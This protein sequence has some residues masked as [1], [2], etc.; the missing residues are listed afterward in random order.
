MKLGFSIN[1][2]QDQS[3]D[4]AFTSISDI[5]YDGIEFVLDIPHGFLPIGKIEVGKIKKNLKRTGLEITNLNAN[6]VKGFYNKNGKQKFEPSLSSNNIK[7]RKW[8]INYTKQAID[9]AEELEAPS[10]SITSGV[11]N[12]SKNYNN[13]EES[14][15]ELNPYAEKKN[16]LISIE[17]EP[18]LMIENYN[19]VLPF[20]SKE[21]KNVGVNFDVCHSAVLNENIPE[22][23]VKLKNKLFHTHISDCKNRVHYH[24]IP[25]MGKIDFNSMY[26]ALKKIDYD[27]FLTGELYTYLHEPEKAAKETYVY[28]KNLI[29]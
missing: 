10:I 4:Y 2:Y 25:G 22:T 28:L 1:A 7:S 19:N 14:I 20:I 5:G 6:T 29:K 17:Y 26:N 8:R 24:L 23:I 27:G 9:L 18:G 21:Y 15:K 11:N 13:F 12:T 3:I 16:I